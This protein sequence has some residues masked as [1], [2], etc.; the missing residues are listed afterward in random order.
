MKAISNVLGFFTYWPIEKEEG[1]DSVE[2]DEG[3]GIVE[4]VLGLDW[5]WTK[6]FLGFDLEAWIKLFE[7]WRGGKSGLKT[8]KEFNVCMEK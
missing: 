3:E 6:I 7:G 8:W 4:M 2:I 1:E 5:L